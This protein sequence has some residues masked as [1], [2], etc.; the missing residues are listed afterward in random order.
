MPW[1]PRGVVRSP[2]EGPGNQHPTRRTR[3]LR[4]G[5]PAALA[6]A[7]GARA[8]PGRGRRH[9]GALPRCAAR[10]GAPRSRERPD[11]ARPPPGARRLARAPRR[12]S[13][14][15]GERGAPAHA[16]VGKAHRHH[17]AGGVARRRDPAAAA[18]RRAA[19]AASHRRGAR[20]RGDVRVP[21]AAWRRP[22]ARR[23]APRQPPGAARGSAAADPVR[24]AGGDQGPAMKARLEMLLRRLGAAGGLRLGGLP[25]WARFYLTA[26]AP[27]EHQAQ[28]QRL[29]LERL[30]ARTPHQPVSPGGRAGELRPLYH[31][32]PPAYELTDDVERLHRLA[33]SSGLDLAQGEYRLE[34]RASGLWAYRVTLPVR[35]S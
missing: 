22:G 1:D 15:G 23:R 10:G 24:G 32:F 9:A 20:P 35:G 4:P 33:R 26:L 16:A 6:G 28:A 11:R 12:G 29:A 30:R 3:L 18:R 34:R 31:L 5:P 13:E 2:S 17:R 27:L 25:A 19:P 8:L 21:A 14:A 7:G